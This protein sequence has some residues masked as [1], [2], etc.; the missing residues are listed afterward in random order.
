MQEIRISE[1]NWDGVLFP[2]ENRRDKVMIVMSGSDGGLEHAE[3]LARFLRDNGIPTLAFGY[4]KTKHTGRYLD[5]IPLE[6]IEA[7]IGWLNKRGYKKIGIEGV[8]KGAEYALAAAIQFPELSCV[9]VKTPSWFYSEGLKGQKPSGASCWSYN[10]KDL[11]YTP[12]KIR[13]FNMLKMLWKAK[14]YNM[15]E[16]NSNKKVVKSSVIPV[17]KIKAPILMLSVEMDTVWNSKESGEKLTARLK[18]HSFAYPYKHIC[19]G[20]MSHMMLEYCGK[21]I[22]YF[23]KSEKQYPEDCAKER[24]EMGRECVEW[25]ENVW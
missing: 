21:E 1:N 23:I 6:L 14:E 8:S 4:F 7:A 17:E 25:I 19:Y 16:V 18:E 3:K 20:H 22:R 10:G 2:V 13:S 15:L 5:R 24:A 9:I 11:S 12:Y